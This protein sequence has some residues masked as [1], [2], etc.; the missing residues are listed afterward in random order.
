MHEKL[1]SDVEF[2]HF[3]EL[4]RRAAGVDIPLTKKQM[5][6]G[7]L[8][9]RLRARGLDSFEAY[10]QLVASGRD[11]DEF[12]QVIDLLTTHETYF[13][14]EPRHFNVLKERVLPTLPRGSNPLRFWSAASS[15]GEEA[16]SLAMVL[17]DSLGS[18][19]AWE[20]LGSDISLE[21]IE[22][23]KTGAYSM[24]RTEGIPREYFQRYCQRVPGE[25]GEMLHVAPEVRRRV[26]FSRVN[27]NESMGSVGMFDVVFLRNALIYFD[28]PSKKAI[29]ERVSRQM[30]PGGWLF[31]GHSESLNGFDLP[32]KQEMPTVYRKL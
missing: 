30:H 3:R 11:R 32:F 26:R 25:K 18:T 22:R 13:F 10:Y 29:V 24:L 19:R 17:M 4:M 6:S 21:V 16:Y 20:I 8:H 27:L 23:A 5:V 12:E 15:T 7:R 14:R 28:P 31:I 9:R 1:I 2:N